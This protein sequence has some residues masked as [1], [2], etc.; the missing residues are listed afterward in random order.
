MTR[1]RT[2]VVVCS[3]VAVL[4]VLIMPQVDLPD[5]V[6]NPARV[7]VTS[8]AH[9][10]SGALLAGKMLPNVLTPLLSS[11]SSFVPGEPSERR[12]TDVHSLLTQIH[13]LRC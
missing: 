3:I 13:T 2:A 5:A 10:A 4:V 11:R 8:P 12:A 6:L 1:L 9:F 7:Q